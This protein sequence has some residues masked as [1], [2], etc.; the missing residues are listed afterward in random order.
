M[1]KIIIQQVI[2]SETLYIGYSFDKELL[3]LAILIHL[4]F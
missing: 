3:P 1:L 4:I 2:G